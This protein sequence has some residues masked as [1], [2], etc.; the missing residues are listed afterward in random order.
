M[1][2]TKWKKP[3]RKGYMLHNFNYLKLW[4]RYNDEDHEKM[5]R[6]STEDFWGSEGTLYDFIM[7]DPLLYACS[8]PWNVQHQE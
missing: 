4:K 7:T 6:Q 3:I 8:N 2:I 5:N 1:D